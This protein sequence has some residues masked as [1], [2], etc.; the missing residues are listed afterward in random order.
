MHAIKTEGVFCCAIAEKDKIFIANRD[1]SNGA[2]TRSDDIEED[3]V[4]VLRV[5]S[6]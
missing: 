3:D 6:W 1:I 5:K 4:R 2:R